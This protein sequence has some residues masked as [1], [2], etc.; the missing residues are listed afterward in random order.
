MI[1]RLI[2]ILV[3]AMFVYFA[4]KNLFSGPSRKM[5]GNKQPQNGSHDLQGTSEMA[6]D[7]VCGTYVQTE[8]SPSLLRD[9]ERL[10]FC[11]EECKRKFVNSEN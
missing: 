11:S 2:I 9:G 10:Y 8:T 3:L 4:I 5:P 7:P 6:Q 1:S